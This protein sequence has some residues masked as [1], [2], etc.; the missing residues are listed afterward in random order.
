MT[1][2]NKSCLTRSFLHLWFTVASNLIPTQ[3]TM[4][5]GM[6]MLPFFPNQH[7]AGH[8]GPGQGNTQEKQPASVGIAE[9]NFSGSQAYL[10]SFPN[11]TA[12]G[13]L[14]GHH[15]Q[16]QSQ[17]KGTEMSSG[18]RNCVCLCVHIQKYKQC[19]GVLRMYIRTHNTGSVY[20]LFVAHYYLKYI[21][22]IMLLQLSQVC[23]LC[24]LHPVPT[25]PPA[26]AHLVHVH[27]SCI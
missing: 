11:L 24:P 16:P 15:K 22:L 9:G 5:A 7:I 26:S 19:G 14:T 6:G 23:L 20:I 21:L 3:T 13:L 12:G 25:F 10:Q 17:P 4:T 18:V 8:A 2:V 1:I 27:G